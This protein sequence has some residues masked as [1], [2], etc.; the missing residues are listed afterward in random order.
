MKKTAFITG[1]SGQDGS[2]LAELLLEKDYKVYGLIRRK[3][4]VEE[5]NNRLSHITSPD[6]ILEYGD[7]NDKLSLQNIIKTVKPDEIY[8]LAAQS[9]VGISFNIPEYTL[10]TNGVA[11]CNLLEIIKDFSPNSKFL[12]A[13]TSEMFGNNSDKDG[14]QRESTPMEPVSPYGCAKYLAHCLIKHYRKAYGLFACSTI[15]FN[16]ESPRRGS[17]FVTQKIVQGAVNIYN[18][19]QEDL[20]LGNLDS[21]RDFG[22]AKDYVYADW[23]LLQNSGPVD[24]VVATGETHSVR[25]FCIKVF[26]R[27]AMDYRDYV[28]ID[29]KYKRPHELHC[30]R[31]DASKIKYELGWQ[32]FY[33]FERLIDDMVSSYSSTTGS[34]GSSTTSCTGS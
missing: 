2:Y 16:H 31:G 17:N 33:T 3:S 28:V 13:S 21:Q 23:L 14:F 24:Y 4:L 34:S 5:N 26:T 32:P 6:L 29:D 22:H 30:L 27:L 8:N 18:D 11:V 7:M 12:Q 1:V 15:N 9:H 10:M 25:E 19:K 20:H